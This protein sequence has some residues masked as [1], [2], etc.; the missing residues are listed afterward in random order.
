M[1]VENKNDDAIVPD[2]AFG[3]DRKSNEENDHEDSNG[4]E[5]SDRVLLPSINPPKDNLPDTVTRLET[6]NGS[7]VY[8][9]G[10]A[11]FSVESQNDVSRTIQA[12]RPNVVMVELCNGRMNILKLDE[13]TIIKES[14]EISLPKIRAIIKQNGVV[15][16]ILYLFLLKM[17]AHVTEQL[18]MAPGGEFRRAY[19]EARRIPGCLFSLGD[20]PIQIT[21]KRALSQL[22]L[23]QKLTLA[24]NV[25]SVTNQPITK[26]DVEK[27]KNKDLIEELLA[28]LAGQYPVFSRVFVEER[29]IYLAK[30]LR[31][32][33]APIPCKRSQTGYVP[34]VTVGVVGIGH[35]AGI[36]SQWDRCDAVDTKE[37]LTIPPPPL[38]NKIFGFSLRASSYML[39]GWGLYKALTRPTVLNL[40]TRFSLGK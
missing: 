1:S 25:M 6:P 15:H 29:D 40:L 33:A 9:V 16:G 38:S 10:T 20:R 12:T 17:S 27:C 19:T 18:G 5:V 35:V 3:Y 26:E 13:A 14:K 28:E 22:T 30:S 39:I 21:L 11:H 7:V 23:W 34:S 24:W 31:Q 37:L 32:T 4:D 36:V 8:I 2:S